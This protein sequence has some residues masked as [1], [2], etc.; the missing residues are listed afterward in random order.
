MTKYRLGIAVALVTAM[1]V[2]AYAAPRGGHGGAPHGGAPH[3]GG[4]PHGGA[5]HIGGA[6]HVGGFHAAPHVGGGFHGAPHVGGRVTSHAH[7]TFRGN[8]GRAHLG[9]A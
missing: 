8:L 7:P 3:V 1:S 2:A 4:A 6:P 9:P 5:P